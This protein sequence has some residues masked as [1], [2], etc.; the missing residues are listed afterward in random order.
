VAAFAIPITLAR[1]ALLRQLAPTT[2]QTR[3][4]VSMELTAGFASATMGILAAIAASALALT[5][6]RVME[7]A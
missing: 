4:N 6:A 5:T 1:T 2:A 7:L 3:E